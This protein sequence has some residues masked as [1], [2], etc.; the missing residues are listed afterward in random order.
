MSLK[1][2]IAGPDV[3]YPDAL[4]IGD[5]KREICRKHGFEGIF[6]LD[7][8]PVDLFTAKYSHKE[9][10]KIIQKAC[11]EGI[12]ACDILVANMTPFRGASMDI[13][14]GVEL[15]AAYMINKPVFGYSM[16]AHSYLEKVQSMDSNVTSDGQCFFD[17]KGQII[18]DMD[19]IDNCM[20]TESCRIIMFPD[21]DL[22]THVELFEK[23]IIY[24]KE[25]FNA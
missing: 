11:I 5:A 16:N 9:Q 2:Y 20:T 8:L 6:P 21:N 4:A 1:I 18:E 10:A 25:Q 3:F 17:G 13:G 12:R 19:A 14:T 24:I 15:G 7:L 22:Q 23:T